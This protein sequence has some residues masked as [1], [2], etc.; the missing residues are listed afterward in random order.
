MI[1][2]DKL[3]ENLLSST[4]GLDFLP[5]SL[6]PNNMEADHNDNFLQALL[7]LFK[8]KKEHK[9]CQNP[10]RT[11]HQCSMADISLLF[12]TNKEIRQL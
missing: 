8:K 9:K 3:H 2:F 4:N 12:F 10:H 1:W 11:S 6:L 5:G 7:M